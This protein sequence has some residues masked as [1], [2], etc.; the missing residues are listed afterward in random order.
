MTIVGV[1]GLKTP[2]GLTE[3]RELLTKRLL[4]YPRFQMRFEE[5]RLGRIR[6]R[7]FAGFDIAQ[8]VQ[9]MAPFSSD[10]A[11]EDAL[12]ELAG[13]LLPHDRPPWEVH[14]IE[15]HRDGSLLV[16][17]LHHSLADGISLIQV[18]VS[19][20]DDPPDSAA[21]RTAGSEQR[22]NLF[23]RTARVLAAAVRLAR[24]PADPAT[25]LKADLTGDKHVAWSRT[26]SLGA[27]RQVARS[28]DAT[29]NDIL[30]TALSGA[31]R[32]ILV[33]RGE[34]ATTSLR[35]MVPFNLRPPEVGQPLGNRFGLVI[36]E[37]PVGDHSRESRLA[38]MRQRMAQLRKAAEG[39]AAYAVLNFMGFSARLVESA[40]VRFFGKKSSLVMTNVPGP[41]EPLHLGG[42]T[43][44]R[45]LFWVPQAGGI[46]VGVSVISYAGTVI[47]GVLSD[48]GSLAEPRL[49]VDAFEAE[50][51]A[52]GAVE[53]IGDP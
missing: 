20:C 47:M 33:S 19:L 9:P 11:L 13:T 14:L 2:M 27:L 17:R 26:F 51:D 23:V 49:L 15:S 6:L 21:H 42:R 37:M 8:H 32:S 38:V 30:M 45:L 3:L 7:P 39:A 12:G 44:N 4:R 50:L 28:H 48:G 22:G 24:K 46:A 52:Y 53:V 5:G 25:S 18:L 36:P 34:I 35:A 31:L 40:L 1:I 29:V 10:G 16:V 41:K 43:I